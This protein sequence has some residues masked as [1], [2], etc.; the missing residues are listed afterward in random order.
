MGATNTG[1]Y[2]GLSGQLVVPSIT[3][4]IYPQ[5]NF[6]ATN[7]ISGTGILYNSFN[8]NG[9]GR[10]RY[11]GY[12]FGDGY[13]TIGGGSP[14][15]SGSGVF[16]ANDP[17]SIIPSGS[18]FSGLYYQSIDVALLT[19]KGQVGDPAVFMI[20]GLTASST[21]GTRAAI[22]VQ[23]GGPGATGNFWAS[24]GANTGWLQ[25]DL[26]NCLPNV[27]SVSHD[28]SGCDGFYLSGYSILS[29]A[30]RTITTVGT[31]APVTGIYNYYTGA[32]PVS[33]D[34]SGSND[35]SSWSQV[36]S[37]VN[38]P[39]NLINFQFITGGHDN[40][41]VDYE[42]GP[43]FFCSPTGF[44][45]YYRWYFYG[46]LD[47]GSP[48]VAVDAINIV[49]T[50][51]M[52]YGASGITTKSGWNLGRAAYTGSNSFFVTGTG[53]FNQSMVFSLTTGVTGHAPFFDSNFGFNTQFPALQAT[54]L[55]TG[56]QTFIVSGGR[57]IGA[58][59]ISGSF[60]GYNKLFNANV[61]SGLQLGQFNV[62]YYSGG[63]LVGIQTPTI[64]TQTGILNILFNSGAPTSGFTT[65][66]L[67]LWSYVS[68]LGRTTGDY[69]SPSGNISVQ[70]GGLIATGL[71]VLYKSGLFS[72][73]ISYTGLQSPQQTSTLV[74]A[75]A[76]GVTFSY[77]DQ[78]ING[79]F[80]NSGG[81]IQTGARTLFPIYSSGYQNYPLGHS[82]DVIPVTGFITGDPLTRVAFPATLGLSGYSG[83]YG[84]YGF[85]PTGGIN[86][87]GPVQRVFCF[88]SGIQLYSGMLDKPY[89]VGRISGNSVQP[90]AMYQGDF[91]QTG[92]YGY[93][94]SGWIYNENNL[95]LMPYTGMYSFVPTGNVNADFSAQY[96]HPYSVSGSQIVLRIPLYGIPLQAFDTFD[97]HL[98]PGRYNLTPNYLTQSGYNLILGGSR[99]STG[100]ISGPNNGMTASGI[101]DQKMVQ[102]FIGFSQ[103]LVLVSASGFI[104]QE[105][106][107]TI[108]VSGATD[109]QSIFTNDWR[110]YSGRL[111]PAFNAN[112]F[113]GTSGTSGTAV[114]FNDNGWFTQSEISNNGSGAIT[115]DYVDGATIVVM[116]TG[117][118]PTGYLAQLT[119]SGLNLNSGYIIQFSGDSV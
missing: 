96:N 107:G 60:S 7:N 55:I 80:Y 110:V 52:F 102:N 116:Y 27:G 103:N 109:Y 56:S 94:E 93:V 98:F 33:W 51:R 50:P 89:Y 31:G 72:Y 38:I 29:E 71:N 113:F 62:A 101:Y 20:S 105:F 68:G 106:S 84:M 46:T 5:G 117:T 86:T 69:F 36:D 59:I 28:I 63:Q 3:F 6:F 14:Y 18:G 8:S 57:I 21:S 82:Y 35:L 39:I 26:G 119:V 44:Y 34:I 53:A 9:A 75:N 100:L 25:F 66:V 79:G 81:F 61:E 78:N 15:Q 40:G 83:F 37:R 91:W 47:S 112:T 74:I 58:D 64:N 49:G 23:N 32:S 76:T 85:R 24:S 19:R 30:V 77:W 12:L 67:D 95:N 48:Y 10:Y 104:V 13:L 70:A 118:C 11:T 97:G 111:L 108:A 90:P 88:F 65:N 45:K 1:I 43:M 73:R 114:S 99:Y 17:N 4:R 42:R 54:G 115:G 22:N 41:G 2:M 16:I 92:S 87:L